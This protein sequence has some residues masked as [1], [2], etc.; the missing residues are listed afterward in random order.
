MKSISISLGEY[1][2]AYKEAMELL[3]K[4]RVT[5][6]IWQKLYIGSRFPGGSVVNAA[7]SGWRGPLPPE[8]VLLRIRPEPG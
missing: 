7:I 2:A 5:E 3:A 1:E 6:R 4:E 8:F